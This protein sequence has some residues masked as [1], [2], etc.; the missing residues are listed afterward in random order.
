MSNGQYVNQGYQGGG[1]VPPIIIIGGIVGTLVII[2][3]GIYVV[4]F[5][6]LLGLKDTPEEKELK[7]QAK[8]TQGGQFWSPTYYRKYGG[9]TYS[10]TQLRYMATEL[11][12]ATDG[13]GT[14]E[15]AI[16]GVLRRLQTKGNI[17]KLSEIYSRMFTSD[18]LSDLKDDMEDEDFAE[19]VSKPISLYM[20]N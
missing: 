9:V 17:S 6:E 19:Y 16:S 12:E 10:D 14:S 15:T 8:L 3:V 13:I 1:G 11:F 2:G 20:N 4:K 7:K 18:L 5:T